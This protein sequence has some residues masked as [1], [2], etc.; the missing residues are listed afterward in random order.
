MHDARVSTP[1][2]A[3]FAVAALLIAALATAGYLYN[4]GWRLVRIPAQA[5]PAVFVPRCADM[6][7][8]G[9]VLQLRDAR[10]LGV[11]GE[12]HT[13]G[14]HPCTRGRRLATVDATTGAPQGYGFDGGPYVAVSGVLA[15]DKGF[16]AA[17]DSCFETPPPPR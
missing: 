6:F 5:A 9:Q 7:V 13:I 17:M 1:R 15:A 10:C 11:H 16:S 12:P 2:A 3:F 8:P 14:W 4:D